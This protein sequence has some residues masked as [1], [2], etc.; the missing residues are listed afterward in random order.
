MQLVQRHPAL[1]RRFANDHPPAHGAHT[2]I[3]VATHRIAKGPRLHLQRERKCNGGGERRHACNKYM[4][5]GGEAW[6]GGPK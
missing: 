6:F 1:W 2:N 4:Y 5:K 3:A